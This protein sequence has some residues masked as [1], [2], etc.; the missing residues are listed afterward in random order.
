MEP[1]LED[2]PLHL[3]RGVLHRD[4]LLLGL[5]HRGVVAVVDVAAPAHQQQ[6]DQ[7][8]YQDG[9]DD[10]KHQ[11]GDVK[12]RLEIYTSISLKILSYIQFT[13]DDE[14]DVLSMLPEASVLTLSRSGDISEELEDDTGGGAGGDTA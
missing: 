13:L 12:T 3:A 14:L 8:Q 4:D 7:T 1:G 6:D 11:Q 2:L 5:G 10:D 9:D